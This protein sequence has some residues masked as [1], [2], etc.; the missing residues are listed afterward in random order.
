[1]PAKKSTARRSVST[2]RQT[3]P[4]LTDAALTLIAA[5]F[6]ALAEPVRLRL[7]NTLMAD[8]HT[9]GQL[10]AVA[11]TGQANVSKHLAILRDA[12][13]ISMRREGLSTLCSIADPS[14][15]QLCELMCARLKAEHAGRERAL[16][17]LV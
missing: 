12:G 7:L 5:R 15:K 10:V 11:G 6:R 4:M 9:V 3:K 17:G 8:E 14:V 16:V 2:V 1:M 13:M